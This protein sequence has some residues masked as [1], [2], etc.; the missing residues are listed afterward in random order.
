MINERP[1]LAIAHQKDLTLN[2]AKE[3]LSSEKLRAQP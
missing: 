3:Q 2:S 1:P